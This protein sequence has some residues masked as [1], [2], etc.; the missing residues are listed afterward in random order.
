M[1]ELY[2]TLGFSYSIE[3]LQHS[4]RCTVIITVL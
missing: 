3:F 1:K 2:E 4:E